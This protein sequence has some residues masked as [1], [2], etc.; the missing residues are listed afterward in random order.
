PS[1]RTLGPLPDRKPP[2]PLLAVIAGG[3]VIPSASDANMEQKEQ[4]TL[5]PSFNQAHNIQAEYT[6]AA[7]GSP[8]ETTEVSKSRKTQ[9]QFMI[10]SRLNFDQTPNV[11]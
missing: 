4:C 5:N 3:S 1:E 10:C 2:D 11:E 6:C 8:L 7:Q 9:R